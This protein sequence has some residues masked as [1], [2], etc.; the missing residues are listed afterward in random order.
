MIVQPDNPHDPQ[1]AALLQQSHALMQSLFPAEANHFL[2]L[3]AL[4][5]PGIT[6]F[7]ARE[8]SVLLG[9]GAL[10]AKAAYGEVKSMFTAADA[11]GKGVAR[12]ILDRIEVEAR[13][14]GL[15]LLLL[16]TG[17]G[18]DAAHRLYR[19]AGFVPRGPFGDYDEGPYSLFF[20]KRL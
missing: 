14:R 4:A 7:T 9:T 16:E 20:E 13:A 12:A 8:G 19:R 15:P 1:A 11:R 3:D 6:F 17:T 5:A 2:S 10:A 18:L